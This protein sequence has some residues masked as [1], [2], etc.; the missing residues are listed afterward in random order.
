MTPKG[1]QR[2]ASDYP[3]VSFVAFILAMVLSVLHRITASD[4][5]LVSFVAFILAMALSVLH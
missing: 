1:N 2:P 4:Y 3:L 5:P